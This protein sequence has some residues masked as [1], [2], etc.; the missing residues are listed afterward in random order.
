M[1]R[2]LRLKVHAHSEDTMNGGSGL[3]FPLVS[4]QWGYVCEKAYFMFSHRGL[5]T[6]MFWGQLRVGYVFG[7]SKDP[8][9]MVVNLERGVTLTEMFLWVSCKMVLVRDGKDP[10]SP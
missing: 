3:C 2:P 9:F 5:H 8:R 10:W 6:R 7:A 4:T 1:V